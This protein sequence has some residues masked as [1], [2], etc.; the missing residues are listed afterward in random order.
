M[1][2][3]P[4]LRLCDA[5]TRLI[6]ALIFE[7]ETQGRAP[8][9]K[10]RV[11]IPIP[12]LIG[13]CDSGREALEMLL[14]ALFFGRIKKPYPIILVAR[15]LLPSMISL[16]ERLRRHFWEKSREGSPPDRLDDFDEAVKR[17]RQSVEEFLMKWPWFDP[18]QIRK[19]EA[20]DDLGETRDARD[21]L[22]E[23][24]HQARQREDGED[25]VVETNITPH[26]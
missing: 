23:L 6:T 16:L 11:D 24:L 13:I 18:E 19:S 17:F 21:A 8:S 1:T 7:T 25:L 20:A 15:E 2:E 5:Q 9:V 26:E 10:S 4:L 22:N 3:A 14:N 12:E